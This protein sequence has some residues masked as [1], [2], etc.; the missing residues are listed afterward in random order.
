MTALVEGWRQEVRD[1]KS[2]IRVSALSP[3]R[4]FKFE[5]QNYVRKT[6]LL[7]KRKIREEICFRDVLHLKKATC[8]TV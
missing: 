1:I 5:G 4:K 3:G 8:E 2:N 6:E 7:I